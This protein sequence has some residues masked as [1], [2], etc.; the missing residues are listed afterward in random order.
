MT[1]QHYL[2]ETPETCFSFIGTIRAGEPGF[3]WLCKPDG[4]PVLKVESRFVS[5][6]TPEQI[7]DRIVADRRARNPTQN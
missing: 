6:S 1:I 3:T 2:I 5:P 4:D 7:A